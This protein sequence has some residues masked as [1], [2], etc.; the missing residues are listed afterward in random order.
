MQFQNLIHLIEHRAEHGDGKIACRFLADVAGEHSVECLTYRQLYERARDIASV[1]ASHT[2]PGDRVLL[3][4]APGLDYV[5]CFFG[6][7]L[8]R[9]IAVPAYPPDPQRLERTLPRLEA[10]ARDADAST[11]LSTSGIAALASGLGH[12]AGKLGSLKWVA[13]DTVEMGVGG[14]FSPRRVGGCELAFLQY[15]SG[16]TGSPKGIMLSHANLLANS[17]ASVDLFGSTE[18]DSIVSWLPPYHDMGLIG[19]IL[20]S[21]YLGASMTLM[22]PLTFLSK[23]VRWLRA[24]ERYRGT[25]SGGPNFAYELCVRKVSDSESLSLDLSSW[26]LAINGAEPVR[27][28]TM[29]LFS[30]RFA[31]TGFSASSFFPC[32]G[33]AESSLLVTGHGLVGGKAAAA[34]A[35][36]T[37]AEL[38]CGAPP[39]C[40]RVVIVEPRTHRPLRDGQ[41][42]E[43]WVQSP[44]VGQG[45]WRQPELSAE[46]FAAHL[47]DGAGPYLRTGDLGVWRN[48]ELHITGRIKDVIIIR[49]Q[50]VYP[51]DLERTAMRSHQSLRPGCTAAFALQRDGG[52][53]VAIAQEVDQGYPQ[54]ELEKIAACI[55]A[56]IAKQHQVLCETVLLLPPGTIAKTSSGKIQRF[57]SRQS[58]LAGTLAVLHE[59]RARAGAAE[60]DW[61]PE[62]ATAAGEPAEVFTPESVLARLRRRAAALLSQSPESINPEAPLLGYGLDSLSIVEFV[63]EASHELGVEVPAALILSGASLSQ[64][65][66][67]ILAAQPG[68]P[69]AAENPAVTPASQGQQALYYLWQLDPDCAAYHIAGV[70][71]VC[72]LD[73]ARLAHALERLAQ[74]HPALQS[75]FSEPVHQ[76]SRAGPVG[77]TPARSGL[78][79]VRTDD[80]PSGTR[81]RLMNRLSAESS[82]Q[83][84]VRQDPAVAPRL[85]VVEADSLSDQ[86]LRALVEAEAGR[87]FQLL[88]GPLWRVVLYRRT[89]QSQSVL[90]LGAHHAVCDMWSLGVLLVDLVQLYDGIPP[91]AAP[92]RSPADFVAW[93][94]QW[95]ASPEAS[96]AWAYWQ[97]QLTTAPRHLCLPT[98]FPRTASQSHAG[99]MVPFAIDAETVQ[100]LAALSRADNATLFA[101]L[102]AGFLGL[103]ARLS[104]NEQVVVGTPAHGRP[105]SGFFN[106]VGYFVNT[107]PL[108]ADLREEPSFQGLVAQVNARLQEALRHQHLPFSLLMERMGLGRVPGRP[109]FV[110]ALFVM[111]QT[112][113]LPGLNQLA[114]GVPDA[115]SQVGSWAL[116]GFPTTP[117]TAE[118]DLVATLIETPAGV[119]GQLI[120]NANLWA[121]PTMAGWAACLV[122]FLR[123]AAAAPATGVLDL[124]IV[125]EPILAKWRAQ[126]TLPPA[127]VQPIHALIAEHA[128]RQPQ[129]LAVCCEQ[130]SLTYA[131]LERWAEAVAAELRSRGVQLSTRVGLCMQ[132]SAAWIVGLLAVFK[133]GGTAVLMDA[134]WPVARLR[135]VAAHAGLRVLVCQGHPGPL[136]A[137]LAPAEEPLSALDVLTV[138]PEQ[139]AA[140]LAP[141]CQLQAPAYV[142]YTSGSSGAPKGVEVSHY[143][144]VGH[145]Q[146]MAAF[147][148]LRSDD[149]MLQFGSLAFDAA[150]EQILG[151]LLRCATVVLRGRQIWDLGTFSELAGAADIS[152]ADL[153]TAYWHGLVS[154]GALRL[155]LLPRLRTLVV[156]GEAMQPAVL[157]RWADLPRRPLLLNAYG[158]TEATITATVFSL[159]ADASFGGSEV[160]IGRPLPGKPVVLLDRRGRLAA[161][162]AQGELAIGGPYLAEGYLDD[163]RLTAQRFVK[164][165]LSSSPRARLYRSGDLARW[166]PDGT[167]QYLGRND[168]QLKVRGFRVEPAEIESALL[169]QPQVRQAAVLA[170]P[171][172]ATA[173]CAFVVL[174]EGSPLPPDAAWAPLR[175]HLMARLPAPMVPSHF[176]R[177]D[178]LP[179][180]SSGKVDRSALLAA[181]PTLLGAA[182]AT[183][184]AAPAQGLVEQLIAD[185]WESA[186]GVAPGRHDNFFTLGGHSLLASELAFR[187]RRTFRCPLKLAH[188]M[189]TPTVAGWARVLERSQPDPAR[190]E[191]IVRALRRAQS[192]ERNHRP[193]ISG[194]PPSAAERNTP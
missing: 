156:G 80:A 179:L 53:V 102:L 90:L 92:A 183:P 5:A 61:E 84:V 129:Q 193:P 161:P 20:Q 58:Y 64:L 127:P 75:T 19:A 130:E 52:E 128:A 34:F 38:S 30:E 135:Q 157:A 45:Y 158:P 50:N 153:P 28:D 169:A 29:R 55:R 168:Q 112:P 185:Q 69:R 144:L 181:A 65:C 11:V 3:L 81:S 126:Q 159:S 74:R 25:L 124:D 14:P 39:R 17:R 98:D 122:T 32:Y 35:A 95:L 134:D 12:L 9:T 192:Q 184:P 167:L 132:P 49:G 42:G 96:A 105:H 103:L 117:T 107:L 118:F 121:E 155:D 87:P 46:V 21:V 27:G 151:P 173:L 23:P 165:P 43:I 68:L 141:V 86:Q 36:R 182:G 139:P 123:A 119:S 138:A 104:G 94:R 125:P 166:L 97:S 186:L 180:S 191:A 63:G 174:A 163:E 40:T 164:N 142:I 89:G 115:A 6:C 154:S 88:G 18:E 44:S 76:P 77:V 56:A 85:Q 111:E 7:L 106:T 149:R 2:E 70:A 57:A 100:R 189:E 108:V 187:L 47:E 194:N 73:G 109:D 54:P 190:A 101:T 120:Y 172:A 113:R 16:S 150:L 33:L 146:A 188:L 131:Q 41:V 145:L 37:G 78:L 171:G 140:R 60:P 79:A 152:I 1:L 162:F 147:L 178:A 59:H 51:Q 99:A 8:C 136:P 177:L 13:C 72:D 82:A 10:I 137:A 71:R 91:S 31:A 83:V 170:V 133:A 93:Q 110:S 116:G 15:S 48:G 62:P 66:Q 4:L 175:E 67:C 26:R 143:A 176:V 24:I 148:G 22:S 160:P 114:L